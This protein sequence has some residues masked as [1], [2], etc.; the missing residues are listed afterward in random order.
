MFRLDRVAVISLLAASTLLTTAMSTRRLVAAQ[1]DL[2]AKVRAFL[3]DNR[4]QWHDL[5]VPAVDGQTLHD[6]IAAHKYTRA[7]EIGTSTGHS[8]IWIAW[9]LSKTGGR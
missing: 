2:D 5:N 8:G 4:G 1:G 3:D 6:I 7:L 9:A